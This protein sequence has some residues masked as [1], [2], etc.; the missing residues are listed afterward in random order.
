MTKNEISRNEVKKLYKELIKKD[1]DALKREK[2]N[3]IKNQNVLEI[4][5]NIDAIFTGTYLHYKDFPKETKLGRSIADRVKL[6][7]QRLDIITKKKKK[8]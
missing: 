3:S 7:K 1:F 8:T 4:L 5:K 2:S 6:R